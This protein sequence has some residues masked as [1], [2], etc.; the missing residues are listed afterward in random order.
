[1]MTVCF[2]RKKGK[3]GRLFRMEGPFRE[4]GLAKRMMIEEPGFLIYSTVFKRTRKTACCRSISKFRLNDKCSCEMRRDCG[5]I[6][7]KQV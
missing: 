6:F 3:D 4:K 2:A 7:P 5:T 1:M